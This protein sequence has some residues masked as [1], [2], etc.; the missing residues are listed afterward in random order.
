MRRDRFHWIILQCVHANNN[1]G[2][3]PRGNL[4]HDPAHKVRRIF[5]QSPRKADIS[6]WLTSSHFFNL[7]FG[8]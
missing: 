2:A 3:L 1:A 8:F 4:N 7:E 6:S 5:N